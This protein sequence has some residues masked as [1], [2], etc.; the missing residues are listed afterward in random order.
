MDWQ[1]RM[2]P[3]LAPDFLGAWSGYIPLLIRPLTRITLDPLTAQTTPL[4]ANVLGRKQ[5]RMSDEPPFQR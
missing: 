3:Y 4:A 2:H 5:I 1:P